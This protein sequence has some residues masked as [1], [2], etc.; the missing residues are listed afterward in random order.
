MTHDWNPETRTQAQ[1]KLNLFLEARVLDK[2]EM[3]GHMR[4]R[5]FAVGFPIAGNLDEPGA[6]SVDKKCKHSELDPQ[7]LFGDARLRIQARLVEDID[8]SA[9]QLRREVA[10]QVKKR[11]GG[12][13]VSV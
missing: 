9:E 10:D 5:Q 12:K 4:L 3:G 2:L 11:A 6:Y 1:G 13:S 7:Q 8:L